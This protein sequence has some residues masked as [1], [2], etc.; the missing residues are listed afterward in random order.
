MCTLYVWY[1]CEICHVLCVC[2]SDV[3]V[4]VCIYIYIMYIYYPCV[5]MIYVC[6]YIYIYNLPIYISVCVCVYACVVWYVCLCLCDMLSYPK[7]GSRWSTRDLTV[8]V[9]KGSSFFTLRHAA[10]HLCFSVLTIP[11]CLSLPSAAAF[12]DTLVVL[13]SRLQHCAPKES[14]L[15]WSEQ[16]TT[17]GIQC[18]C[19]K[20]LLCVEDILNIGGAAGFR[21]DSPLL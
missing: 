16:P 2:M 7:A 18:T 4:Y 14:V 19:V 9:T 3:Y 5:S 20:Y 12:I 15:G 6:V 11:S 21:V 8:A 1:M 13:N 10:S 17:R